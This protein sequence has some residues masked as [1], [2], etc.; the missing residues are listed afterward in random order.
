MSKI[1]QVGDHVTVLETGRPGIICEVSIPEFEHDGPVPPEL[2]P[3]CFQ[4]G[5]SGHWWYSGSD[6]EYVSGPTIESL[7]DA[8]SQFRLQDEDEEVPFHPDSGDIRDELLPIA[9]DDDFDIS[10]D[11]MLEG[12]LYIRNILEEDTLPTTIPNHH[13]VNEDIVFEDQTDVKFNFS[14]TPPRFNVRVRIQ[15]VLVDCS[16]YKHVYQQDGNGND[17]VHIMFKSPQSGIINMY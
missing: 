15:G 1:Y 6:L 7:Q 5:V 8:V 13:L 9:E 10:E 14:G 12:E 2:L 3:N 16:N 17:Y 11:E 4:Y